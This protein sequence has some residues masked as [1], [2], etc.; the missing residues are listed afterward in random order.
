MLNRRFIFGVT[1]NYAINIS[2]GEIL[3]KHISGYDP[4][5]PVMLAK[6]SFDIKKT[7]NGYPDHHIIFKQVH[8]EGDAD[9]IRAAKGYIIHVEEG[10]IE[11]N[12]NDWIVNSGKVD[13]WLKVVDTITEVL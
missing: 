4:H 11:R 6:E 8:D 2:F 7:I 1:S 5:H 10:S 9:L 13:E 3:A 12:G